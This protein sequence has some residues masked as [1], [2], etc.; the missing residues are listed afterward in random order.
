MAKPGGT[1]TPAVDKAQYISP[2]EAF[3]PP[4]SGIV[5]NYNNFFHNNT[6]IGNNYSVGVTSYAYSGTFDARNNFWGN[7]SGPGGQGPG[8]ASFGLALAR[9]R[10]HIPRCGAARRQ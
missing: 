8:T 5:A 2:R 7:A 1:R 3:L 4:T 10:L 9:H 6:S